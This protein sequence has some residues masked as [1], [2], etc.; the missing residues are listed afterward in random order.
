MLDP[1]SL[2]FHL[3]IAL[4]CS[5]VKALIRQLTD[6]NHRPYFPIFIT[7]KSK[8][9]Y[10]I[11]VY[12]LSGLSETVRVHIL[13]IQTRTL[14]SVIINEP[15]P[16]PPKGALFSSSLWNTSM[17]LICFQAAQCADK[18]E[19]KKKHKHRHF[20]KDVCNQR[21]DGGTGLTGNFRLSCSRCRR[22][23]KKNERKFTMEP[24]PIRKPVSRQMGYDSSAKQL[25]T[26]AK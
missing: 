12:L 10:A 21:S 4:T 3:Y 6:T 23:M 26:G 19:I 17:V 9:T 13:Y 24:L 25:M 20:Q 2:V 15:C 22:K 5:T 11:T 8:A 14:Q 16:A 18:R 1:V 7:S